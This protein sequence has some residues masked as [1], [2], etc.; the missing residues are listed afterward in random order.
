ML[1]IQVSLNHRAEG[2]IKQILLNGLFYYDNVAS[3]F[4]GLAQLE[5][6]HIENHISHS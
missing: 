4:T 1:N 5:P 6:K 2:I 3:Y